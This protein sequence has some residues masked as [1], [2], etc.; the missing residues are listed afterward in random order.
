VK[1]LV[2]VP[3]KRGL[4]KSIVVIAV[5]GSRPENVVPAVNKWVGIVRRSVEEEMRGENLQLAKDSCGEGRRG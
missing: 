1:E 4:D 2:K 3:L 5:D